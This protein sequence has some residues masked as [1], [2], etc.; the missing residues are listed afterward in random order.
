[1]QKIEYIDIDLLKSSPKN[2]RFIKDK[3]F[4]ILC[5]SI[6]K[7]QDYFETR[8]VLCNAK[9]VIFAGTQRW[10]AAKKIGL[11]EVPTVIMDISEERQDELMLRDNK[12]SG[13]WNM[14]ILANEFE[15]ELLQE[16]GFTNEELNF[17]VEDISESNPN[18]KDVSD[19]VFEKYCVMI[20]LKNENEQA[21]LYEKLKEMGYQNIK[22]MSI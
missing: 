14:E 8:P 17:N 21:E 9:M 16:V 15:I 19:K 2:P 12:S 11:K 6:K 4:D 13:E 3:Q 1:M 20:E 7:N 5:E 10:H 18:S 22:I